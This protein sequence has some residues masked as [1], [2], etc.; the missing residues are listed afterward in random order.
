MQIFIKQ[1]SK[2]ISIKN[3][4]LNDLID[5]LILEGFKVEGI[6]ELDMNNRNG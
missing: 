4:N 1:I 2:L 6:L 5:N 3:I